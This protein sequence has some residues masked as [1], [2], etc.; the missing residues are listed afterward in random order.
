MSLKALTPPSLDS[1]FGHFQVPPC[2][3]LNS[4]PSCGVSFPTI[5]HSSSPTL[6]GPRA[7]PQ[8]F[9][10]YLP[11]SL[12]TAFL[13]FCSPAILL[14]VTSPHYRSEYIEKHKITPCG[15][16][17]KTVH[18]Q[19]FSSWPLFICLLHSSLFLSP[20]TQAQSSQCLTNLV[21]LHLWLCLRTLP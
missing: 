15:N 14:L 17:V 6:P 5:S 9:L 2:S 3:L 12:I 10:D 11:N 4:Y 21:L 19:L 7:S 18:F 20:P 16:R 1:D 8:S 13:D